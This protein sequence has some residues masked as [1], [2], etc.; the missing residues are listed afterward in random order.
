[1]L[2]RV[3]DVAISSIGKNRGALRLWLE[4]R[5]LDRAGF[6]PRT[7]FQIRTEAG[8]LIL[9]KER[10]G[11]RVVSSRTRADR[12]TPI[13][14][15]NSGELLAIFE[16]LEHVRVTFHEGEIH[17]QPLASELRARER[18]ERAEE[19]AR[20]GEPLTFGSLAHGGGVMD[21][22][23]EAGFKLAGVAAHLGFANEIRSDLTEQAIELGRAW[24]PTTVALNGKMQE[25]AFDDEIMRS[26]GTCDVL[27]AGLP[28]S[29]ASI[30]GRAKRHLAHPEAHPEVG[31]LVVPFLAIIARVN[32]LA[33]VIENVT[34][35]GTTASMEIIRTMLADM[36]YDVSETTVDGADW[37]AMENRKRM[38][39][40][41]V[42]RGM[43]FSFDDLAKPGPA[44]GTLA[45]ILEPIALDDPR[46]STM[47]GLKDKASRDAAD[48]QTEEMK[49]KNFAMQIFDAASSKIGTLTKGLS[50]NRSTDP[51]I[52]HPVNPDLLRVPTAIEHARAK[53]I[54]EAMIAGL[55]STIAQEMLG[56]SVI[57]SPFVALGKLLAESIKQ[58]S[59]V[60]EPEP[61]QLVA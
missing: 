50:K 3:N 40:V 58:L 53:Q 2:S 43:R 17:I 16:G 23:L 45:D 32:P 44:G 47:E 41:A 28:C 29:G 36:H 6:G 7:R 10:A 18:I 38:V 30:A 35:Y 37:G 13:I 12:E 9:T 48:G 26:I 22:A 46:W 8:A 15:I 20:T 4:G 60:A 19:K 11:F 49:G 59:E 54:P 5:M 21:D 52:Q 34:Q 55:S 1:M 33:I 57:Y 24:T 42:T 56:Q 27:S 61:F 14:D 51:K 31:H 39:M 25:L